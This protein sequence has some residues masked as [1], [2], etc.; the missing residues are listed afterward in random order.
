MKKLNFRVKWLFLCAVLFL[1]FTEVTAQWNP[2]G[3]GGTNLPLVAE[4][5]FSVGGGDDDYWHSLDMVDG[6]GNSIVRPTWKIGRAFSTPKDTKSSATKSTFLDGTHYSVTPNPIRLD[7][8]RFGDYGTGKGKTATGD[9]WGIVFSSGTRALSGNQTAVSFTVAGLKNNGRYTVEVEYCNPLASTYLETSGSN[10]KPHLNSGYQTQI[11]IGTNNSQQDGAQTTALPGKSGNCLTAKI[12]NPTN[13][14][15]TQGPIENNMLTVNVII[16]QMAAGEA[17]QI[18][19]IKVYAELDAKLTGETELCAGGEKAPITLINN[20]MGCTYQWYRDGQKVNGETSV[21]IS[22]TS[23]DQVN[24]EHSYYCEIKTPSGSTVKTETF[25]VKDIECCVDKNGN[26]ASQKLI[27]QDDFGTFTSEKNY[28]TWDYSDIANPKKVNHTDGTKWQHS[29]PAEVTPEDATFAVVGGDGDCKCPKK[30]TWTKDEDKFTEGYYTVAANVTSYGDAGGNNM[31]WVGYFGDGTEPHNNGYKFA[32]DHTYMGED[33]GAMLYLNIGSNPNALIYGRKITGLCDRHVTVKCYLN[34]FSRSEKNPISVFVRVTDLA[35]GNS[36]E[37]PT[38]TRY[39]NTT[40]N[41]NG[42]AWI[43]ASVSIDL[44][45]SEMEFEIISK[46]GGED[47]NTD[48]NDLILDDIMIYACAEPSVDMYFDLSTHSVE[49]KSCLGDDI[50]LYVDVTPMIKTNIGEDAR[51]LY[52]YSTKPDDLESWKTFEGPTKDTEYKNLSKI[53]EQLNLNSKEKVYFRTVLGLESELKKNIVF[54]PNE[55][56][57]SYSVSQPIELTIDCPVCVEPKDPV[58]SAKGGVYSKTNK[59]VELC[60]GESV[61]LSTNDITNKDKDGKDYT[62]FSLTWTKAGTVVGSKVASGTVAKPLTVAYDD[63]TAEGVEY[64]I[65]VHDNFENETGTK[66]CDKTETI[67]IIA[68]PQPEVEDL[69]VAPFCEGSADW[70][71]N[72]DEAIKNIDQTKYTLDWYEDAT[73]S[74][75]L[76]RGIPDMSKEKAGAITYYYQLTDKKTKCPSEAGSLTFTIEAIPSPLDVQDVQYL[77]SGDMEPLL[78]HKPTAVG[79]VATGAE[80]LWTS[81]SESE[82][83]TSADSLAATIIK[84]GPTPSV[85]DKE[86]TDDEFY[87][88]WVYQRVQIAPDVYCASSMEK[89]KI[90]ILGAPAPDVVSAKYCKDEAGVKPLS[91]HAEINQPDPSNPKDYELLFYASE[92]GSTTLDASTLPDVSASGK[93]TYYVSQREVGTDNESKRIPFDVEVYDVA[94]LTTE[95]TINYCVNESAVALSATSKSA[96]GYVQEATGFYWAEGETDVTTSTQTMSPTPSTSVAGTQNYNVQPYY[97]INSTQICRGTVAPITVNVYETLPPTPATIQYIKADADANNVFPELTS[98]PTWD[99]ES[100]FTYYYSEVSESDA[101]PTDLSQ[102]ANQVPKPKYDVSKLSGGTKNLY[103]WVYRVDKNN[104]K[105]CNSEP[106]M[107]TIRISDALP[108]LVK[109]VYVCEGSAVPD[110]QAEVQ[111]LPS[112]NKSVD[113]YELRW[114]GTEDP[115]MNTSASPL[116]TGTN[117]YST[118]ITSAVVTDNSKT[119]YTYYVTQADKATG[120][121]SASSAIVVTV[122]PKPILTIVDPDPTCEQVIDL[123]TT[124]TVDNASECGSVSF[125]YKDGTGAEISSKIAATD[126]YSVTASYDLSYTGDVIVADASCISKDYSI[127]AVVDSLYVP[128][129]SGPTQACPLES[130]VQLEA[131]VEHSTVAASDIK[132]K[133][134]DK[135]DI[136]SAKDL[137]DDF[138]D[139]PGR[140]FTYTVTAYAGVCEKTSEEHKITVGDG[141]VIGQMSVTEADNQLV[142]GPFVDV[143]E[144]EFYSCGGVATI[145]VDYKKTEGDYE[146]Y[147]NGQPTGVKGASYTI[148]ESKTVSNDVYEVR[149]VNKCDASASITVHNIPLTVVPETGDI[150]KCEGQDFST[151]LAITCSE[152]P[153]IK[154]FLN[155]SEI[156]GA[157]ESLYS[158]SD[159]LEVDDDGQYSYEVTNRGCVQAGDSKKL[160]VQRW[161]VVDDLKDPIIVARGADQTIKLNLVVP[162]NEQSPETVDWKENGMSVQKTASISYTEAGVVKDHFYEIE[163]SDPNYCPTTTTATIWVDAELQLQTSLKDTICLGMSDILEIDT[164]GTGLF[165]QA[166]VT[167]ELKVVRTIGNE[168]KE[169]TDELKLVGDKLQMEVSPSELATYSVTFD[170]GDQHKKAEEQVYVIEAISLTLPPSPTLCEGE[171]TTLTVSDVL[172]KGTTVTWESDPTITSSN[173]GESVDIEVVYTSGVDHRS[174]YNYIAVAYNAQCND[175]KSYTIPVYVDEALRGEITGPGVICEGDEATI[176]ASSYDATTYVWETDTIIGMNASITDNP[177]VPTIYTVTM[178]RGTCTKEDSYELRVTTLP[179]ITS[180]DSIGIRERSIETQVGKGTGMFYYWVDD[181]ST[182]AP[183]KRV[184]G[185]SFTRHMA[186]VR[187]ENG[188][189]ASMPFEILPPAINIPNWFSPNADQ[190]C[191]GWVVA[192][193]SEAYPDADVYIYDRYGKLMAQYK[194]ADP[195]WDGMYEGKPMP[196]TDYWY[197]IEIEEIEKSYTGHFTLLRR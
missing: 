155:G 132:Y 129:I 105:A 189:E 119:K 98:K 28:W 139:E 184:A 33:Y 35:S 163:L 29:L 186:N 100:G 67:T 190:I 69:K 43:P 95:A 125:L 124:I 196:S 151:S 16:S 164:V 93:T 110:L 5:D 97:A 39:A 126:V 20:F 102:Y 8:L 127:K 120:A 109:D 135:P 90:S 84:D 191:D 44:T 174:T 159:L 25:K 156:P 157:K 117:T 194:G 179:V 149:F 62:D 66:K 173:E 60:K 23:G 175:S 123:A 46:S 79:G 53:V 161:I 1:F 49:E 136:T 176:D 63:V 182:M 140:I 15:N 103:C 9:D 150:Q 177:L 183:D 115:M 154:W 12:S 130:G 77:K 92:S 76:T 118:G 178:E 141:Q 70:K 54:N 78:V 143:T 32:P 6:F 83:K 192:N 10:T 38:Y 2:G 30:Y 89:I 107:L 27:W 31:G 64:M 185:L 68:N 113:D 158:K 181:E 197:V 144:R 59:T 18:K 148:E 65:T 40:S 137:L 37:S 171:T 116:K 50:D 111:L 48:G 187:D 94:D 128:T 169:V 153:D 138:P 7:S 57:G 74:S 162:E 112:S 133:W 122:L 85:K 71:T 88:T 41:R 26:P 13:Y 72:F 101:K 142:Q 36:K 3:G 108:P 47:Q 22:H 152:T 160:D 4:T 99:E 188:C 11:K 165:R 45:G 180:V 42:I 81:I 52:Q 34:C 91:S 166:G 167:P 106:V 56:C 146:W 193:L 147:K 168:I 19:S 131:S 21:S 73:L 96:S 104:P 51:Y 14:N 121:E 172:P 61:E 24:K 134:S 17:V 114:Y 75:A 145:T 55:P 170:Y 195:G 80:V 86:D 87:Y 82:N 58:I